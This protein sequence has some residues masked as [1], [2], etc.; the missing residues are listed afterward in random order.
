MPYDDRVEVPEGADIICNPSKHDILKDFP[1]EWPYILGYNRL[2]AK[3]EADVIVEFEN[4]PIIALG[5][6]G[7]GR[8]LA[9]ATDCTAHWAPPGMT[10][11]EYYPVL[12]DRL[13]YWLS[14]NSN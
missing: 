5:K 6:F 8:T 1:R 10:D 13:L 11:W 9:Y 7:S 14:G 4:D 2:I 12:W 3:P